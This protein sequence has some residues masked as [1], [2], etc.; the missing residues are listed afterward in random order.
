MSDAYN[1]TVLCTTSTL[2]TSLNNTQLIF[3][4]RRS[5]TPA[6]LGVVILSVRLS[7]TRVLY[8]K[9]KEHTADILTPYE[10]VGRMFS[11]T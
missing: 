9:T 2:E 5:N 10:K 11:S 4:A 6:V 8:D 1:S 7:V 3:T